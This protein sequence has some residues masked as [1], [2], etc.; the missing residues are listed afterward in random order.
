MRSRVD[1]QRVNEFL[2]FAVSR[3]AHRSVNGRGLL[4][5]LFR[6]WCTGWE[7]RTCVVVASRKRCRRRQAE[8]FDIPQGWAIFRNSYCKGNKSFGM[9]RIYVCVGHS[10][11]IHI[12]R[13]LKHSFLYS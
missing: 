3:S 2:R 8:E 12:E 10:M 9:G 11:D 4:G 5:C 13:H 6:W 7:R 1:V